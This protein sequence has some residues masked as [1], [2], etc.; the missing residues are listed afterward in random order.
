VF[1][2]KG[3]KESHR[4]GGVSLLVKI[5]QVLGL[6]KREIVSFIGGGGKTTLMFRL[7]EEIPYS[8]KVIIT[9]TTKI[10]MP[11]EKYPLIMLEGREPAETELERY[12][13]T[14]LRPVVVSGKSDNNKVKGITSGQVRMLHNYASFILVEA[15]GSKRLPLKG[16][17]EY[18]PVIPG[19]TTVLVVVIGADIIGKTLDDKNVHRPG[20]VSAR[21]GREMGSVIDVEMIA[22]LINHPQG[23]LRKIPL[24]ARVIAFINKVDCLE[25]VNEGYRLGRLLLGE[26]VR[27]VILGSAVAEKPV[28]D[29]ME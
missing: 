5:C 23:L 1:K 13:E 29:M 15:D 26:K 21:T 25:D 27:K 12:L 8:C 19:Q 7:A 4:A 9:T 14:G 22:G 16:H 2:F 10:F 20:V 24:G 3:A 17:L 18:E 28:L 11:P 6:R